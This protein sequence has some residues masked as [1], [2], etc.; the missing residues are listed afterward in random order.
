MTKDEFFDKLNLILSKEEILDIKE[1]CDEMD[2]YLQKSNENV[3]YQSLYDL[4]QTSE[5][6]FIEFKFQLGKRLDVLQY[7]DSISKR[8]IM[9]DQ[10]I[11]TAY[12][13]VLLTV[14]DWV[15]KNW[16]DLMPKQQTDLINSIT[17]RIYRLVMLSGKAAEEVLILED[18]IVL[19]ELTQFETIS[20]KN[21]KKEVG[22][23]ESKQMIDL[24]RN[25]FAQYIKSRRLLQATLP[26]LECKLKQFEQIQKKCLH[27]TIRYIAD[28]LAEYDL[29]KKVKEI[30]KA[31]NYNLRNK[32]GALLSLSSNE[33][34]EIY[35]LVK[36]LDFNVT[37]YAGRK[38]PFNQGEDIDYKLPVSKKEKIDYVKDRLIN[39]PKIDVNQLLNDYQD[40]IL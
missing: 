6:L 5:N 22:R 34:E 11:S 3:N 28:A 25:E 17:E 31:N 10:E 20:F 13:K 24:I 4:F 38:S 26:E 2:T 33:A 19:K 9:K 29:F 7:R 30:D 14:D 8:L 27:Y 12:Q 35:N 32:E 39:L 16:A 21:A 36:K 40:L 1:I 37:Y 18:K 15:K 23:L